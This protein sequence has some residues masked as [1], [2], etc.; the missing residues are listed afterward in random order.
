MRA[1]RCEGEQ[2]STKT[3]GFAINPALLNLMGDEMVLIELVITQ[4]HDHP[5]TS[6]DIYLHATHELTEVRE[7][8]EDTEDKDDT[9]SAKDPL[10]SEV[11]SLCTMTSSVSPRSAMYT[12][13]SL[14]LPSPMP[15]ESLAMWAVP[16]VWGRNGVKEG[17]GG[18]ASPG[19]EATTD[20]RA[21]AN[22]GMSTP[23]AARHDFLP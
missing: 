2:A 9:S 8:D 12:T 18:Q 15:F 20:Q 1:S 21:I 22:G 5:P 3:G 23:N 13:S 4:N 10:N 6:S 17:L 7:E 16:T 19:R 11:H 14:G